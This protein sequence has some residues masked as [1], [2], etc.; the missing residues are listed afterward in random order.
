MTPQEWYAAKNAVQ[1]VGLGARHCGLATADGGDFAR[2]HREALTD[3][4]AIALQVAAEYGPL[5]AEGAR[6]VA[7]RLQDRMT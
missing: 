1:S 4:I 3:A 5:S 2:G 7:R 6:A